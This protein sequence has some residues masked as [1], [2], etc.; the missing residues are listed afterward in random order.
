MIYLL[1]SLSILSSCQWLT[2]QRQ[3]DSQLEDIGVQAARDEVELS[4]KL[5]EKELAR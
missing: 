1:L 4:K 3:I 2:H 5:A